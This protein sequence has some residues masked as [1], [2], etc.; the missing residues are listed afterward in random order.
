MNKILNFITFGIFNKMKNKDNDN[1]F[2]KATK[3]NNNI[4]PVY[5]FMLG[6]LAVGVLLLFVQ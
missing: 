2:V 1:F 5:V 4:N 6:V 3:E